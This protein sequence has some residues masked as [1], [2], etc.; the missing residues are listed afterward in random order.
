MTKTYVDV[1]NNC[2]LV[3][4][5]VTTKYAQLF[6]RKTTPRQEFSRT[7]EVNRELKA[8][9]QQLES[10]NPRDDKAI[11]P[12]LQ[13]P[14]MPTTRVVLGQSKLNAWLRNTDSGNPHDY[15]AI[16]LPL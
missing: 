13:T 1:V 4:M 5:S 11:P 15:E 7:A 6:L 3:P 2:P 8:W 16:P 9:S 14:S 10:G 12:P